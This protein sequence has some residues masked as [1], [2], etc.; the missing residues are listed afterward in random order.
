MPETFKEKMTRFIDWWDTWK[1]GLLL[2][3]LALGSGLYSYGM[4]HPEGF[5]LIT[6]LRDFYANVSSELVSIAITVLIIDSLNRR[7][8][9]RESGRRAEE[10]E[11][12]RT[13]EKKSG[14]IRQLGSSVNAEA[15]RAGEE[16]RAMGWL[17]DGSAEGAMLVKADLREAY[18]AR[19][20][21]DRAR[22]FRADLRGAS[23]TRASLRGAKMN[24][25]DLSEADMT[26]ADLTGANMPGVN[27]TGAKN[28]SEEMLCV[29]RGLK[30][31]TMPD[32]SRYDG[33]YRLEADIQS[34]FANMGINDLSDDE[35][36][37]DYYVVPLDVYCA[38]QK[39][40]D[41]N[42]EAVQQRAQQ[43]DFGPEANRWVTV[44][45]SIDGFGDEQE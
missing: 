28:V 14:L 23:L 24:G 33:R 10:K 19:G 17:F 5:S 4:V 35:L 45:A 2:L 30:G 16:L 7:R 13:L 44:G 18:L 36:M 11:R 6:L 20:K 22:L 9:R 43:K 34:A 8:E 41:E 3:I 12:E 29:L 39:W 1:V 25:A 31:A 32:G 40:A 26:L 27:L 15:K 21:L 38:G 37:A 42:L